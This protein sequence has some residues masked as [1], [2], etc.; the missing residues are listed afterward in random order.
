MRSLSE[1]I[2]VVL[3]MLVM[4]NIPGFEKVVLFMTS[5]QFGFAGNSRSRNDDP[6]LDIQNNEE[7]GTRIGCA[8]LREFGDRLPDVDQW[9]DSTKPLLLARRR[10]VFPIGARV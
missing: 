10:A 9:P 1:D 2:P 8:I 3:S 5:N 4:T 7:I 6:Q